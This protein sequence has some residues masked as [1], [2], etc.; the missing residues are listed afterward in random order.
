[1][2]N[3]LFK[4]TILAT[5]ITMLAFTALPLSSAFAQGENPP[6]NEISTEK[7]EKAW[8]HQLQVYAKL[9]K[10]FED[11][12]AKLARAQALIDKVTARGKDA[13]A[14]QAALNAFAAALERSRSLYNDLAVL[15]N[16]HAGFDANG[17]LTDSTQAQATVQ[18]MR[19][20]LQALKD[21]MDGTGR[22]LRDA[23]KAFREAN[24]PAE[25]TPASKD[26]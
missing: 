22:A 18:S 26:S 8:A 11:T 13:S 7:L 10:A 12:D 5:L 3:I 16:A 15:V 14:I 19:L 21:S 2:I 1:M 25:G 4:K 9:G 24:K 23:L 17:R 6:G 20:K